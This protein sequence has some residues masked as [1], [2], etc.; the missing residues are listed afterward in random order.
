MAGPL[1]EKVT[2]AEIESALEVSDYK[3][4]EAASR[5]SDLI[6]HNVS[7]E[8]LRYWVKNLDRPE[9]VQKE[10]KILIF[11]IETSPLT[12]Y[13]WGLWNQNI[14]LGQI[15][16]DWYV[17]CWSAKWLNEDK[18]LNALGERFE[19][20][21]VISELWEMLDQADIVVAHNAKKFDVK[22]MNAKFIEYDLGQPS[23]YKVVDTLQIAKGNFA[24]TSNKLDYITKLLD[25][26][27]KHKTD[28][29][30]WKGCMDGDQDKMNEMQAYC[31]QDV[32]E[33]ESIYLQLR[34][35]DSS[36]PSFGMYNDL[37]EAQ[38]NVCGCTDL[39]EVSVYTTGTSRFPVYQCQD[40][41]HQQRGRKSEAPATKERQV[42]VR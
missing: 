34:S 26:I 32:R 3:I 29:S 40:C 37:D 31:D 27:G 39:E 15:L 28:F 2:K 19:E 9:P 17:I 10:P 6:G 35:W 7:P 5:L 13:T 24:F 25:G 23:Y 11:D 42:N 41:G 16:E 22:K 20:A 21:D 18:I 33:L 30:L 38:C 36:H 1:R 14:S 8:V 4:S 12:V